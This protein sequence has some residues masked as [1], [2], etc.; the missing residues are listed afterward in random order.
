MIYGE[1]EGNLHL[2]ELMKKNIQWKKQQNMEDADS[3]VYVADKLEIFLGDF[4]DEPLYILHEK[5][6]EQGH[7]DDWPKNWQR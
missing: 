5:G 3:P 7:F 6:I 2:Q 1:Q 4:P